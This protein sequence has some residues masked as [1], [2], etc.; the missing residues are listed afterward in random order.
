MGN[1]TSNNAAAPN[2]AAAPPLSVPMPENL[3]PVQPPPAQ[4]ATQPQG[5]DFATLQQEVAASQQTDRSGNPGAYEEIHK[6][7]KGMLK[8]F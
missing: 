7:T 2:P 1:N 8:S 3:P 4:P 5:P 6:K